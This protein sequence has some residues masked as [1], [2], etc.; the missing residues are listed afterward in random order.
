MS[1]PLI[2]RTGLP[3]N[4]KTLNTIK[5]VDAKAFAESRVV[6]Y[7]NVAGLKPELLKAQWFEFEDPLK[8]M[9]L[10]HN[11][12]IVIDEAQG[13]ESNPM[14]GVRDPRKPVP[15]HVSALETIRHGG[16]ELN[17]ITQDPR[18]IDV[19][20]RRLCNMHIH[21]WRI[22]GS[23]KISRYETPRVVN[24]VE[25]LT[26]FSQ[27]SREIITL[28]KKMFGV[29][30]SS[31]GDHHFK[32][33]PSRKVVL[34]LVVIIVAVVGVFSMLNR[35]SSKADEGALSDSPGIIEQAK[36]TAGSVIPS[37]SDA[38]VGANIA[39][40][41]RQQYVESRIPRVE[42]LPSSAPVYDQLTQP[43]AY[44]K[45][46][47]ASSTDDATYR[48][49]FNRMPSALVNGVPTVCQCYT[50]QATRVQ[51]DF[52]FCMDMVEYGHFDPSIPDRG[53]MQ[54][55]SGQQAQP[56]H[57]QDYAPPPVEPHQPRLTIVNSGKPGHLW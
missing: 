19:H 28:D 5:E 23:Q 40:M 42:G 9:E 41:T 12:I 52:R 39:P 32:F 20:A 36:K 25:K 14:F 37:F 51:T 22:F 10:P 56:A 35:F 18:F 27:S 8:W 4:G 31:K 1:S 44:P 29:Y 47:C 45:L 21:Y 26:S 30:T 43:V 24:E 3:G 53:S 38:S 46:Y 7:H 49:E 54:D 57:R 33:R 2:L 13:S 17:L 34:S 16:F 55:G 15:P 6:Y 48:R 50:Q 11:S